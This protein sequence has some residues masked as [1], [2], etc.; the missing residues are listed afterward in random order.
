MKDYVE[1]MFVEFKELQTKCEKL[2]AFINGNEVFKTLSE[3]KQELMKLQL[4][5]MSAYLYALNKRIELE[6]KED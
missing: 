5:A 3:E 4:H 2:D 1:R 6:E